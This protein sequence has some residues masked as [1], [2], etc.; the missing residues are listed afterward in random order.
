MLMEQCSAYDGRYSY[1][2]NCN[3]NLSPTPQSPDVECSNKISSL[4]SL[5]L[6][7]VYDLFD[8]TLKGYIRY[9]SDAEVV[10]NLSYFI[11]EPHHVSLLKKGLTFCPT[12]GEPDMADL[13]R[14]LDHFH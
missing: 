2:M 4:Y 12:P 8:S 6:S 7:S 9:L 14:D 1:N 3:N 10:V 5:C 11:L 13:R